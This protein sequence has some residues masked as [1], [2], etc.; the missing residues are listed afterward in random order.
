MTCVPSGAPRRATG[1]RGTGSSPRGSACRRSARTWSRRRHAPSR[2]C[3][4]E[5]DPAAQA[6]RGVAARRRGTRGSPD[7]ARLTLATVPGVRMLPARQRRVGPTAPGS[8][9]LVRSCF[10]STAGRRPPGRDLLARREHDTGHAAVADGDRDD[11]GARADLRAGRRAAA[12]ERL[13]EGARAAAREDRLTGG[14][15]V[16]AGRVGQEHR[17]GARGPRPHRGV[18]GRHA[19]RRRRQRVRLE[20]LG[21]EVRDRH[22]E[23]AEDRLRASFRPSPRNARPSGSPRSASPKP[24]RLDV[25][26]RRVAELRRGTRRASGRDRS[27]SRYE[28][29]SSVGPGAQPVRRPPRSA[30]SVTARPSGWGAK[31]R[32][33][34]ADE[35]QPPARQS[36]RSR[37][38]DGRSRPT[39]WARVGTR[40][41]PSA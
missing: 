4:G 12:G 26:R 16:V 19:R 32:T 6:L 13:G 36:P 7:S 33:S 37:T 15:A 14:A 10:G 17:G 21:H 31:T 8:T 1:R 39:V 41:P 28:S 40:T 5:D 18:A 30:Q 24:G 25:G 2:R 20:R 23:D 35:G 29:A 11:L 27:N 3:R 22:R 9:S 38:T 34:G